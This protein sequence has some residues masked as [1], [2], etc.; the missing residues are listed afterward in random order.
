MARKKAE[1]M[2]DLKVATKVE[3]T[4]LTS[5]YSTVHMKVETKDDLLAART[6]ISM[7][8]WWDVLTVDP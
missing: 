8:D 6:G 5:V 4:V 1:M 7:A 2:G 3:K